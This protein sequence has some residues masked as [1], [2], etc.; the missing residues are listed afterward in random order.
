MTFLGARSHGCFL[1]VRLKQHRN[2]TSMFKVKEKS[3]IL[4][5]ILKGSFSTSRFGS[6]DKMK[7]KANGEL[8]F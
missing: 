1:P 3:G 4:R 2:R 8:N 5:K 6:A 7:K